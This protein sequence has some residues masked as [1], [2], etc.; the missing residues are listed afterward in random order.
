MFNYILRKYLISIEFL[1]KNVL[2][3]NQKFNEREHISQ[4]SILISGLIL[5]YN[6]IFQNN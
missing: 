3:Y 6:K 5:V 4:A 1:F 2:A